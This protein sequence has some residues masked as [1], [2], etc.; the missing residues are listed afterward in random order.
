VNPSS[1]RESGNIDH[2]SESVDIWAVQLGL[3]FSEKPIAVALEQAR[4]PWVFILSKYEHLVIFPI[5]PSTPPMTE[6]ASGR[7]AQRMIQ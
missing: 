2:T 4:G 7:L 5:H 3:R 6:R 1:K